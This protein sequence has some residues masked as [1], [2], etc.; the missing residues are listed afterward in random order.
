MKV[1]ASFAAILIGSASC[2]SEPLTVVVGRPVGKRLTALHFGANVEFF[3]PGLYFGSLPGSDARSR[4]GAFVEALQES[5]VRALR[6]PGGNAAYYYL[7]ESRDATMALAHAINHWE[8]REELPYNNHF[9]T[10]DNLADLAQ[11]AEIKLIYELP[12]LFHRDGETTRATIKSTMSERAANYDRDRVEQGAAYARGIVQRLREL[13]APVG[14]WELGN[15]EFAHCA[16]EDYAAACAAI[17]GAVRAED[18]DTPIVAVGMGKDW[19]P[20]LVPALKKRGVA[21]E[22]SSYNAHYPFGNWPGPSSE[23]RKGDPT[24][25]VS[26]DLKMERWL[27]G[28][29]ESRARL[30]VPGTGI[31]VTET[32]AMRHRNWDAHL[33]APTH[34]YALVYAWNW[35]TLLSHPAVDMAVLHDLE[36]P[37]FGL[38]RYNVGLDP[39]TSRFVWLDDPGRPDAL[40][41]AYPDEYV[42]SPTCLANSLLADLEG[43]EPLETKVRGETSS[44]RCL[45]ARQAEG[46]VAVIAVNRAPHSVALL[47]PLSGQVRAD[48]LT[49][50]SL[51][52]RLP[53]EYRIAPAYRRPGGKNTEVRLPAW[54]VVRIEGDAAGG[55]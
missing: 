1:L 40:D 44:V 26:G 48:A 17:I 2:A 15:E 5:G 42:V 31:A 41:P 27:E 54:S 25:F 53:G 7:A 28:G 50:D 11:Q 14:A 32:T 3:R 9:V 22:V 55:S 23:D 4:R 47:V 34:A 18:A 20:A 35:L 19:M 24:A 21:D 36:T 16:A 37:F 8:Y 43:C 29:S 33:V 45:A 30:G 6:F 39:K 51:G 38:M 46:R 49:A 10:L 12:V 13:D 52:A